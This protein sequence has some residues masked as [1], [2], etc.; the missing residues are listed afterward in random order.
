MPS[1]VISGRTW[2]LTAVALLITL[3]LYAASAMGAGGKGAEAVVSNLLTLIPVAFG[4]GVAIW[5]ALQ[6]RRG[7]P[8]R[9]QWLLIGIA[10]ATYF[11]AGLAWA[12]YE[13]IL[14]TEV[15][16]PGVPDIF[17]FMWYPLVGAAL[18]VAI[19]S[20]SGLFSPRL[21]LLISF[22]VAAVLATLMWVF[23]LGPSVNLKEL[24]LAENVVNVLYPLVDLIV[25]L[26]LG[27]ALAY[28]TGRLGAGRLA[29]PWRIML[30]GLALVLVADATYTISTSLGTYATGGVSD[31]FEALGYVAAGL[32]ASVALDVQ[33]PHVVSKEGRA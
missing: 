26:P 22:G 16:V 14:A 32:A 2:T 3:G 4:S 10:I 29:W 23:I 8:V 27:A 25:L 5:S 24:S 18:I 13:V 19:R 15:P 33:R 21:P 6:F 28:L 7:E 31:L 11:A 17:Y 20:F 30:L 1:R 12:Y 9:T